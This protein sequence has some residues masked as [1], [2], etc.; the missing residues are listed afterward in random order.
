MLSV[1][2]LILTAF[3]EDKT[4]PASD[5]KARELKV[6]KG[7]FP[8]VEG[9]LRDPLKITSKAE[10]AKAIPDVDTAAAIAK[11]VDF[12]NEVVLLFAWAGSGGDKLTMAE[13]KEAAVFTMAP[14]RTRDLRQHAKIFALPKKMKWTMSK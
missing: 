12:T 9:A 13:V 6:E 14:G 11:Q 1:A 3:P 10:L 8:S 2:M 7:S 4:E 5:T